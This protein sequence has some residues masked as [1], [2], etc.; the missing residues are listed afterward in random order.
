M[1]AGADHASSHTNAATPAPGATYV[2]E[3]ALPAAGLP[4]SVSLAP[5]R[6][7]ELSRKNREAVSNVKL[8][9]SLFRGRNDAR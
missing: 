8:R 2:I 3:Y 4:A 1:G 5:G 7:F 6:A 9:G